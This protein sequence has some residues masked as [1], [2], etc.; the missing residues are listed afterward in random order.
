MPW[1][2]WM[3][4]KPTTLAG[5]LVA[6]GTLD[7]STTYYFKVFAWD[8]GI[9]NTTRV[10]LNQGYGSLFSPYSDTFSI[11]TDASNK[12]VSLTWD[13]AYKRNGVTEVDGYEVLVSKSDNFAAAQDN[14][15]LS[16]STVSYFTPATS[17]NAFTV[18]ANA[19][20]SVS[21][22]NT[23]DGMP[24]MEWD[25]V[26][27]GTSFIALY[28][29]LKADVTYAPF[30]R[31]LTSFNDATDIYAMQFMGKITIARFTGDSTAGVYSFTSLGCIVLINGAMFVA[32]SKIR[33]E[34]NMITVNGTTHFSSNYT[35]TADSI[36]KDNFFRGG[37]RS[38]SLKSY[39]YAASGVGVFNLGSTTSTITNNFNQITENSGEGVA[40]PDTFFSSPIWAT[41]T[42]GNAA[43]TA[44]ILR[45]DTRNAHVSEFINQLTTNLGKKVFLS[46]PSHLAYP[47]GFNWGQEQTYPLATSGV[48]LAVYS[49][50]VGIGFYNST[51][52]YPTTRG[53][54]VLA[55]S[56]AKST[57]VYMGIGVRVVVKDTAGIPIEGASVVFRN[58]EGLNITKGNSA[59][60][61]SRTTGGVDSAGNS[62]DVNDASPVHN[63][64]SVPLWENRGS[65]GYTD[66]TVGKRYWFRGEL[67]QVVSRDGVAA[68]NASMRMYTLQRGLESTMTGWLVG[69]SAGA[70][71]FYEA[72][73]SVTTDV[74][75]FT[76]NAVIGRQYKGLVAGNYTLTPAVNP[77]NVVYKDWF[78]VEV[79]VSATGKQTK[80]FTID[81]TTAIASG[82]SSITLNV[83]L[84]KQVDVALAKGQLVVNAD[85]SNTQSDFFI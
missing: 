36:V 19:S 50:V 65:I 49:I 76:M 64:T 24:L 41:A 81:S 5:T 85:P 61:I 60:T 34:S 12:S 77:V 44:N 63:A 33:M 83:T 14:A 70:E 53:W 27:S 78:P 16:Q 74:N 21:V 40:S 56:M 67:V 29:A 3:P 47:C 51:F 72:L 84:E 39:W 43:L 37:I 62:Y 48:N 32:S 82:Q 28:T 73:D 30:A 54:D 26:G 11:T 80:R 45:L 17:T 42:P 20:A 25:G 71:Q 75:G 4:A 9:N 59:S 8:Y 18:T 38:Y 58:S 35:F 79:T 57:I 23:K 1:T 31:A 55:G 7:A 15:K 69:L 6:G 46:D 66:L 68:Y 13:K 52:V 22:K 10:S 2:F